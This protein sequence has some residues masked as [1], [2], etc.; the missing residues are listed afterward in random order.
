[1]TETPLTGTDALNDAISRQAG[2]VQL[3]IPPA[4]QFAGM[5]TFEERRPVMTLIL[6]AETDVVRHVQLSQ[7]MLVFQKERIHVTLA[8]ETEFGQ[9]MSNAMT[10]I[11]TILTAV[12]TNAEL[13]TAGLVQQKHHVSLFVEI[14]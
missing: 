10:E 9:V 5:D 3:L 13:K 7:D 1:M 11:L 6:S 12:Q 4:I 8:V 14:N 2:F